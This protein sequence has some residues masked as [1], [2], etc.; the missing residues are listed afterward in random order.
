M[1]LYCESCQYFIELAVVQCTKKEC[2]FGAEHSSA[3]C[4]TVGNIQR[5]FQEYPSTS[6]ALA[7]RQDFNVSH[8]GTDLPQR[9]WYTPL[10]VVQLLL[11]STKI[12][13]Y[14]LH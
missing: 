3:V 7:A 13:Q 4:G 1:P 9:S 8:V 14:A 2:V 5:A 10:L 6:A 11:Q 12:Q